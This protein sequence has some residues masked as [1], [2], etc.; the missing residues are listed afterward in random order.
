MKN[1]SIL[2]V[3]GLVLWSLPIF[4]G[5]YLMNDTGETVYGLR[6][7][8]A[9]PVEITGF[10]DVLLS[11][12]P[13]GEATEF[14][15][16]GGELA[17]WGGHWLNWESSDVPIS[18]HEWILVGVEA[19]TRP[20]G[21][22][23][24]LPRDGF[25]LE[26]TVSL[27]DPES[28]AVEVELTIYTRGISSLDLSASNYHGGLVLSPEAME[29]TCMPASGFS[30]RESQW[31][32]PGGSLPL[33]RLSF[34]PNATIS[35]RYRRQFKIEA[36]DQYH[37]VVGYM[38][39][40][41]FL[42]SGEKYLVLP[43]ISPGDEPSTAYAGQLHGI[44]VEYILPND[45]AVWSPWRGVDEQ[46]F[47]PCEY[48]GSTSAYA[49]LV[50]L[51]LST[52]IAG[53]KEGFEVHNRMIG[54]TDVGFVFSESITDIG[55]KAEK[56]FQAFQMVQDLWGESVGNRYLG[57]FIDSQLE[58][59]SG[60]GTNSQGFSENQGNP[61]I[62]GEMFIHQVFHRWN[63]W[64]PFAAHYDDRGGW[65]K[66]FYQ[67]GW[68][69]YYCD[70]TLNSLE[71]LAGDWQFCRDWYGTYKRD[72]RNTS[73]DV[74]VGRIAES[75]LQRG[76]RDWVFICYRKG[77]LIAFMLDREIQAKTGGSR[78]LDDVVKEIWRR[79]GHRRGTFDN[80]DILSIVDEVAGSSLST[81]FDQYVWGN[82]PLYIP[83]LE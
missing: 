73:K 29:F 17:A 34:R 41:F 38:C 54:D 74:P 12:E 61:G 15:F 16:S 65:N 25:S 83:E 26:Y 11:V 50:C 45:W 10:G 33:W 13:Y 22:I 46:T 27:L 58:V 2:L 36:G 67:D 24:Q 80:N 43:K 72:Y 79:Y 53:P 82:E 31:V 4:A 48:T 1:A 7:V 75:N 35:I 19:V 28:N 55:E 18:S 14:V 68:N 49:N 57:V 71:V 56:L 21:P 6:V 42:A 63:G 81:F 60:E 8:F 69:E 66:M 62:V 3:V 52:V 77:A 40:E 78:S 20:S 23:D 32:G 5:D 64:L 30:V 76:T 59:Y 70:K 39:S 51:A 37:G 44:R 9:E 47:D